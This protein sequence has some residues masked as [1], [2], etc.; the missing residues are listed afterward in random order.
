MS[1]EWRDNPKLK[2]RFHSS[3]F[4]DD[5]QVVIHDGGRRL[6]DI[7]PE[8]VWVRIAG[9]TDGIYNG[10]IINTPYQLKSVMQGSKILFVEPS[11]DNTFPLMVTEKYLSEKPD[12]IIAPCQKCGSQE[13]LDAPSELIEILFQSSPTDE[14]IETFTTF[15]VFDGGVQ[16]V[17]RKPAGTR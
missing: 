7:A 9:C 15:C 4:P 3:E 8:C 12:W 16:S 6:T 2:M 1:H 5:I 10:S 11:S 14:A 13:I 17:L